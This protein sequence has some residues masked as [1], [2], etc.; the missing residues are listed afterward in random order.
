MKKIERKKEDY[1]EQEKY[2]KERKNIVK[3]RKEKKK[4]KQHKHIPTY[5]SL[6][7]LYPFRI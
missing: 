7:A 1:R 3:E 4:K 6:K 5:I 2:E